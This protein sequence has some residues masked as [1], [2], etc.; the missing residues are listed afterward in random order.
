MLHDENYKRL[1]ASPL[2]VRDVLRA[3]LPAHRLAAAD[4]SSLGELSPEYVSD[5]LRTRHGDTVWHLRLG[6]RRAFL[7][8]LLEFQAQDDRLM[9]LR[10]LTYTGL[11]LLELARN[12]PP[13]VAGERLPAVLPVVLY[14]GTEPWTAAPDMG[15]LIT[16][17][18]PWLAPYQPAQRYYLI[19][20]QRVAADALPYRNLLR[21]VARL[22][23]SRSPE[24]V[25]RAVTALVAEAGRGG[26]AARVRGLVVSDS[27]TAGAA[28]CVGAGDTD[29]GGGEHDVGRT[30]RRVAQTVAPGRP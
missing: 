10:I 1:F 11:L 14:N 2:M 4:L 18:G 19:D 15:S 30:G 20:L 24:D 29:A 26:V 27:R 3:C 23:Q 6:R 16:P 9:A 7:L 5:E 8:V 17:V 21:A 13:E 28:G 22:E 12:Q 25:M